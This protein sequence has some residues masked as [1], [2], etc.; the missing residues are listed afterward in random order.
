MLRGENNTIAKLL[1]GAAVLLLLLRGNPFMHGSPL[2]IALLLIT[3]LSFISTFFFPVSWWSRS[4][5]VLVS[6]I[7]LVETALGLLWLHETKF[8]Y[9]LA[10]VFFSISIRLSKTRSAVPAVLTMMVIAFLYTRFGREDVFTFLTFALLAIALYLNI[11]SR[12]Q[13]NSMYALNKQHLHELQDAYDDLQ[14]ASVKDM[15]YAVLEERTRIARD[16]HDAVGHS[17]TSLIVQMQAMRYML[18]RD[19]AQAAQS[20][21]GMLVVARQ[22]LH[23]IRT[24][25]HALADDQSRSGIL[26]LKALLARMEASSSIQYVF[27][28]S[29][30]D[31]D[32]DPQLNG[33]WF[34]VLQ[35]AITN[36]IRHANATEI[37]VSLVADDEKWVMRILDNGHSEAEQRVNE[38]FGLKVM[39]ARLEEKGGSLLVTNREPNGFE[40]VAEI[41]KVRMDEH[42]H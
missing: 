24:S 17:L 9:M 12:M 7:L 36:V 42:A 34:S 26:P 5:I 22:G 38:G 29:V 27:H 35:E 4:K 30:S 39:R 40:L 3:Y 1:I 28:S 19:T 37:E 6:A 11:R 21:E 13:R 41:P 15:H 2:Q 14:K 10:I 20:L 23:D 32:L 18:D 31:E 16:I 33:L 8:I 25:V